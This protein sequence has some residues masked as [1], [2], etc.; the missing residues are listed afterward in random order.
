MLMFHTLMLGLCIDTLTWFTVTITVVLT[1]ICRFSREAGWGAARV[2]L[3]E[4]RQQ[5]RRDDLH[6]HQTNHVQRPGGNRQTDNRNSVAGALL[7]MTGVAVTPYVSYL[8][9]S[10][11]GLN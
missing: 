1:L 5:Q 10:T 8:L 3:E 4:E 6:H 9:M 7:G 11:H 2:L